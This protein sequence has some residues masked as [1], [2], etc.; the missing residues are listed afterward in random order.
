MAISGHPEHKVTPFLW[1][2]GQAEAAMKFYVSLFAGSRITSL[3]RAGP[4]PD[5]LVDDRIQLDFNQH[6]G[7]DQG[8]DLDH[9]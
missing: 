6:V 2:D 4:G 9:G 3:N 5:A 7:A 1:F 8:L